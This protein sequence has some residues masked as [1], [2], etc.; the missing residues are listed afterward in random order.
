MG[1]VFP[2]R[3]WGDAFALSDL[4]E[5]VGG[6]HDYAVRDFAL[7][8]IAAQLTERFPNQLVFKG[9]FVLRHVHQVECF[10]EDVDSTRHNPAKHRLE[11]TEVADAIRDASSGDIIRFSPQLPA[12][13]SGRSLDFDQVLVTGSL[14][15]ETQVQVEIS[16][17][18]EVIDPPMT[19]FVGVPFYENF[20]ILAMS[21]VEMAAEKMRTLAQRVKVTDLADLAELLMRDDVLDRELARLATHKFELVK[22]GVAN[23]ETRIHENLLEMA[24]DYDATIRIFYPAARSYDESFSKVWPRIKR[25]IP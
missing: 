8:T 24:A 13:D 17:R 5:Q 20:P 25:L 1:Q 18:E 14:L 6:G 22:T 2:K 9:G 23:R 16:Y 21:P 19:E 10:S 15:Q 7:L 4:I 3:L 12:T 11:A